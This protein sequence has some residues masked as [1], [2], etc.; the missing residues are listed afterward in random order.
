MTLTDAVPAARPIA[1]SYVRDLPPVSF[2]VSA[3]LTAAVL[4]AWD[5]YLLYNLPRPGP[6]LSL[7]LVAVPALAFA[8]VVALSWTCEE[9]RPLALGARLR[10]AARPTPYLLAVVLLLG[11]GLWYRAAAWPSLLPAGDSPDYEGMATSAVLDHHY[12]VL[13]WRTPGYAFPLT[14]IYTLTGI[15]NHAAVHAVQIGMSL[16]TALLVMAIAYQVTRSRPLA[17]LALAAASLAQP[18]AVASA[19]LMT[20]VQAMLLVAL[21]VFLLLA[22]HLRQATGAAVVALGPALALAYETRPQLLPFAAV[23][24]AAALAARH[25]RWRQRAALIAAGLLTLAPVAALNAA[26]PFRAVTAG[27]AVDLV[28]QILGEDRFSVYWTAPNSPDLL[29][30]FHD[31]IIADGAQTDSWRLLPPAQVAAFNRDRMATMERYVLAHAGSYAELSLRRLPLLFRYDRIWD[32]TSGGR[33]AGAWLLAIDAL[34]ALAAVAA[35]TWPVARRRLLA[36]VGLPLA[37]AAVPVA[38]FHVE[39]R[40]SLPALPLVVVLAVAGLQSV[41]GL[42]RAGGRRLRLGAGVAAAVLL[43]V[44][45]SE[46]FF[47]PSVADAYAPSPTLGTH[48]VASCSVGNELLTSV[49]WQPG[50]SLVVAGGANGMVRWD[51]RTG[52]CPWEPVVLDDFW[53]LEFSHDGGR[54]AFASYHAG[55]IDTANPAGWWRYPPPVRDRTVSGVGT[56]ILSVSLDPTAERFAFTASG[57][58]FVGIYDLAGRRTVSRARMPASPV[59]VRWSPDGSTIAA[60]ATD[61]LIRIYDH[62]L[63]PLA[64]A[65]LPHQP[66]ALAWSPSSRI[67]AAGDETGRVALL[68]MRVHDRPPLMASAAGHRGAVR[69]L[70]FSP[71]GR[72]LASAGSDRTARIWSAAE[73]RP[74]R[75]LSG[76]TATV[77]AVSWSP[78]STRVATAAAD[79]TIAIWNAR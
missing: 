66:T 2:L 22:V 50:G 44:P 6:L 71:D 31:A 20:E 10:R 14:A 30:Q 77:W 72:S 69:S 58:G 40:Y 64:E 78:D 42:L 76:D 4:L 8:A 53:D 15:G 43:A 23:V 57:L 39:P 75:T 79:G 46:T 60:A 70:A 3:L 12:V 17:L 16:L 73:L 54:L 33:Q 51:P 18:M 24:L 74:T 19:F 36:L 45:A 56:E 55:V 1:R 62:D 9:R 13:P 65:R 67:L 35:V 25:V 59:A 29:E 49:A 21:A 26:G 32:M 41:M 38:L 5:V 11:L 37:A 47:W 34:L 28:P 48:V 52:R 27:S 68:D 61:G 7:V 63:R